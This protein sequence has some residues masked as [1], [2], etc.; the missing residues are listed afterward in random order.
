MSIFK[1][2]VSVC[3]HVERLQRNFLWRGGAE[4][5][6]IHLLN[7][8]KICKSKKEGGLDIRPLKLVNEAFLGKWLWWLGDGQN[9]LWKEVVMVKYNILRDGW[10]T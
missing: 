5:N 10:D 2:S 1:C 6:R 4:R 8:S 9:G 7:W 3:Q